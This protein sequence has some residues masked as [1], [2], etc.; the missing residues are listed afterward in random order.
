[1]IAFVSR[2]PELAA[3]ET[4][5]LRVLSPGGPLPPGEYGYLEHFCEQ[6]ECDC[7]RVLLRVTSAQP[8]HTVLA[9]I[10]YG[11]ESADF[12]TRWMHGDVQAG[13]EITAASLDP[14]HPQSKYADHLLDFFQKEMITD[15][16]YV[17]RL[18]RHCEMFKQDQ[19]NRPATETPA[20]LPTPAPKM[21]IPEILRQLQH[22]PGRCEF[23]PYEAALRAAIEQREAIV[24]E[25]IAAIDRVSANP[26]PYFQRD[27]TDYLHTF[28]IYLL[29]QFRELRALDAILRFFSLPGEQALDLTGDMVT[30]QGAAV[31]AS[32]CGGDP[33]PLLKL[34]LDD[35]VNEFVRHQAQNALAVQSLWGERPREAVIEDLRRLFTTLPK[36]GNAYVWAGLTGLLCDFHVPELAPVARQ[37]FAEGLVDENVL[38]LQWLEEELFQCRGKS[39]EYFRERNAPIDAIAE[40]SVW[41]CF[42]DEN[43]GLQPWQGPDDIDTEDRPDDALGLPPEELP[44]IPAPTPY[45]APPKI[46]RND[47]CPCGSG[48]KF[49]K[50]CGK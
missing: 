36:P 33:G 44:D 15:P 42:R 45:I 5:T 12:Y 24:P 49:K 7:R 21:T 3:R 39:L 17:A 29:A 50:C 28:A 30:E 14:L 8:P 9:T 34:I 23:A 1:M 4:R 19:R 46:G 10:N 40:C 27:N 26:G 48:K 37:A 16:A 43:E 31:L 47:P 20:T 18:A 2:F 13:S 32:V 25:L 41:L 35:S 38:D 6:P 22:L 11:G